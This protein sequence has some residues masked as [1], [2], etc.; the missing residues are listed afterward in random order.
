[1]KSLE[2][3][4]ALSA[5]CKRAFDAS[6][7]ADE[8]QQLSLIGERVARMIGKAATADSKRRAPGVTS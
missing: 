4:V 1:M 6:T 8:R 5:A 7:D 2:P 3:L